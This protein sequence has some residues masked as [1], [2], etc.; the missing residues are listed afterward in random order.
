M[1]Q[2]NGR[3]T[4]PL[5]NFVAIRAN[6][7]RHLREVMA[8]VYVQYEAESPPL[9]FF[10]AGCELELK[11]FGDLID[12]GIENLYVRS[13][14]FCN[15]SDGMLRSLE[16]VLHSASIPAAEKFAALQLAVAMS[17]EQT[18][19]LVDSGKFQNLAQQ[20]GDEIVN[21]LAEG[22]V[23]PKELF[24]IARHDFS[25]FTHVTNV[26]SYCV[27][28]AERMGYTDP[29][30]LRKIATAAILHDVGKRFIPAKI[31]S[32]AGRLTPA[33]RE[34]IETHPRRGYEELCEQPGL[35]FG[36][37]MMV[38]QHHERVDGTGYPV[39]VTQ[40]EI[41][42]WARMLTVVDVFDSMTAKRPYRR[43][44]SP[45]YVLDYQQQLAGTHFDREVVKCWVSVMNKT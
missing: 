30:D 45:Q 17:M 41:H 35:D 28:L 37:L 18:L 19:R 4:N 12:A 20:V 43:S 32:K 1:D 40:K 8:D 3:T 6:S 11:K 10:R 34:V 16:S 7:L 29:T 38:Y 31:I 27:I 24:H 33:E 15:F 36:Q 22:N 39:R 26:A 9:L 14:D 25:A 2:D 13:D 44:A 42:P 23:L 21:L 5:A